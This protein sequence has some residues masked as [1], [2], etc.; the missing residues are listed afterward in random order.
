MK[1]TNVL[2]LLTPR[3]SLV[4]LEEDMNVRQA[5]EKMRAHGFMAVP[6]ISKGGEYIGTISEGDILHCMVN[7]DKKLNELNN[8][9]V[10]EILRKEYTPAVSYDADISEILEMVMRQNFVPVVDDRNILMGIVTRQAILKELTK[11]DD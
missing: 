7:Y 11:E 8:V 10:M 9:S 2:L 5:Y 3:I 4:C 1:K 6:L